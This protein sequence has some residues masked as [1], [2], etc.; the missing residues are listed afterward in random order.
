MENGEKGYIVN[1]KIKVGD[2]VQIGNK[3]HPVLIVTEYVKIKT[4]DAV[5]FTLLSPDELEPIQVGI[6]GAW[7]L[8]KQ[9]KAKNHRGG[10]K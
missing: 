2:T 5:G 9:A 8:T 4:F 3:I 10:I 6:Q 7:R 1:N